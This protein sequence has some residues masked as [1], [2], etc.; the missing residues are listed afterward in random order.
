MNIGKIGWREKV[1]MPLGYDDA[2]QAGAPR[3]IPSRTF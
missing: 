3:G 1:R 2:I